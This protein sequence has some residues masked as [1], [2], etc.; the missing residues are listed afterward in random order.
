MVY[1]V[2]IFILV[3]IVLGYEF[4]TAPVGYEDQDGFH[5]GD[6]PSFN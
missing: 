6:Y 4:S 2:G 1:L 5:E 3:F